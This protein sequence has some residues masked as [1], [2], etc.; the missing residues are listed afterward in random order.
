MT[1]HDVPSLPDV[2]APL[3]TTLM[4]IMSWP[5]QVA[6]S[7]DCQFCEISVCNCK[8]EADSPVG[9]LAV[10]QP[11]LPSWHG[12]PRV[13]DGLRLIHPHCRSS[14]AVGHLLSVC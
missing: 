9:C 2:H 8:P 1:V 14:T 13:V 7:R 11:Y 12:V 10:K 3:V 5:T 4:A 6:K